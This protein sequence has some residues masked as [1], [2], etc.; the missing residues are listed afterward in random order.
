MEALAK[1]RKDRIYIVG[2]ESAAYAGMMSYPNYNGK[3]KPLDHP[4][5][6]VMAALAEL[7]GLDLRVLI[8]QRSAKEILASNDHRNI[9]GA[10][11][12]HIMVDNAAALYSQMLL[13][14]HSFY[15]CMQF[16]ELGAL[17]PQQKESLA[18]F[19]HPTLVPPI[20]DQ[21]LSAVHYSENSVHKQMNIT[22]ESSL[23]Y[24]EWLL[25]RRLHLIDSLCH[26]GQRQRSD[27]GVLR[28]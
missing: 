8:L 25:E 15:H 17:T 1:T 16:R 22:E 19:I 26:R 27:S 5:I 18:T 28:H 7:A 20:I 13:M 6:F 14:D 4:D 21:M 11:E 10:V 12:P 3:N 23:H 9:G 24:H 2:L